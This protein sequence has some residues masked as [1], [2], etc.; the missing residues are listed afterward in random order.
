ME[1][2]L[3]SLNMANQQTVMKKEEEALAKLSKEEAKERLQLARK[4]R[5]AQFNEEIKRRRIAKIKSKLYH[6]IKK[7]QKQ[8]EEAKRV[9]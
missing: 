1:F 2:Q 4:Q 8:R 9:S 6:K 3:Q 7:R 5:T